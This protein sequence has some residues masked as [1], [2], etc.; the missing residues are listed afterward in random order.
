MMRVLVS[1][2][3]GYIGSVTVKHL[4]DLGHP[5]TVLD[6]LST[7]LYANVADLDGKPN[8]RLY[9]G[10]IRD[11]ALLPQHAVAGIDFCDPAPISQLPA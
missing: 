11:A 9:V 6:D 4:L 7:G 2:G 8:F 5:V 3:A 1:G 10:T